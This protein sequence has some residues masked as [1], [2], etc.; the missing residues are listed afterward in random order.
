MSVSSS[1]IRFGLVLYVFP[2]VGGVDLDLWDRSRKRNLDDVRLTN[3]GGGNTVIENVDRSEEDVIRSVGEFAWLPSAQGP[4][5][6]LN[7]NVQH[8]DARDETGAEAE[9]QKST[10][11]RCLRKKN[12]KTFSRH[13][14]DL[15]DVARREQRARIA[16]YFRRLSRE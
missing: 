2:P 14:I 12:T 3:A 10:D 1:D 15:C 4:E 11:V 9:G 5:E 7:G 13:G 6:G 16:N 8:L